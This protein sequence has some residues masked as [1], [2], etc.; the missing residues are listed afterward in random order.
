MMV[1]VSR[2][3]SVRS[4]AASWRSAQVRPVP[5]PTFQRSLGTSVRISWS[6]ALLPRY[7]P[8]S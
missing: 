8:E 7:T 1:G 3:V 2:A 6:I 5:E 4:W